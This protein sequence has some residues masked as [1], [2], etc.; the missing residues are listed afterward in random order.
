MKKTISTMLLATLVSWQVTHAQGPRT[1]E[2]WLTHADQSKL[3]EKQSETFTFSP[4]SS[5]LPT[6][7]VD[8]KQKFQSMDGFGFT[9]TGGSATLLWQMDADKRKVLLKELFAFDGKN[10]G[11]SYLRVSI[12]ASDLSD[13][14][15]TY[16][17]LPTGQTDEKIQKLDLSE[18]KKALIPVLKEILAI[19]PA[20]KILG[21]PWT[22]PVWMKTNG[23][24]KGGSLLPKYYDAYALYLVKYIQS[25]KKEG[26]NIDAITIQ[27]EPLHPG[28]NPSLLMQP[29]EQGAFIKQ[30]LG[31]AFKSAK[32]TTKIWLYDHN[33][34]RPDYPIAILNDPEVRQYVDGSAFHLY[35]GSVESIRQVH[36]AHPDK[37][38]YFTEQWI[39]SPGNFAG[40]LAWHTK[41]LI[42][43]A[44]RNW[45]KTVLE[46]NLAAD[47]QQ[48]PHTEGGC[49][50]CLGALTIDKNEIKR[51]P[52]YYIVAHA[53]KFVRPNAQRI[54]SN[55]T[56]GL[57]NIAFKT[58][59]GRIV[60][61][62][63]NES[64]KPSTFMISHQNK[65][66]QQTL[67]AGTVAT[68]VW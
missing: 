68:Y 22:P 56:M 3:F 11:I 34:D 10:I 21:S 60:L 19:N 57:Q 13:H 35:G 23:N 4:Q 6:I 61:I 51:N 46:W 26:I 29:E 47:P 9:L 28:N 62:V 58:A 66:I 43:G 31:K 55:T 5:T 45:C 8:E 54:A 27:N 42:I 25:M 2:V 36:E 50:E 33:A 52:A 49:T 18:E 7:F 53:S 37:H 17:D 12:G 24:S 59:E 15:F 38:V 14:V 30:S 39:G 63:L 40:D 20:I 48:N 41:T 65:K 67:S 32:I 1:A 44:V 16:N 64:N